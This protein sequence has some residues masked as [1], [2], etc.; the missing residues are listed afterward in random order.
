MKRLT[1]A[2]IIIAMSFTAF[3]QY[4]Q[5]FDLLNYGDFI[6]NVD[7]NWTTWSGTTGGKEDAMVDSLMSYSPKHS[8]YFSSTNPDG[9]P[10]DVVLEFG[11]AYNSGV[12]E[13]EQA[14]YIPT[15]QGAYFNFQA[16]TEVGSVW[17][18]D[19]H[20]VDD[21][22]M[23]VTNQGIDVITTTFPDEQWFEF[24]LV[25]N[26]SL[27][28]WEVF[29]DDVSQ[30][31]FQN[32]V[33]KIASIDY[34][35]NN[36]DS[37]GGNGN[38]E[39]WID[40][41]GFSHTPYVLSARNGAVLNVEFEQVEIGG[42]SNTPNVLIR[43]LGKETITS[44]DVEVEY[45]S[46][47]L[48]KQITGETIDSFETYVLK[49]TEGFTIDK[50]AT[51]LTATISNVNGGKSDN[52]PNDDIK[53]ATINPIVPAEGRV[54]I[55]E[56]ATG[57][58]CGWCPRGAVA[59]EYLARDYHGIAQGIAVH[60]GDPM[61]V[62]NYEE[63]IESLTSGYPSAMVNRVA[64]IDPSGIWSPVNENLEIAPIA[65]LKNGAKYNDATRT[66]D[67]SVSVDFNQSANS[68]WKL[69]CVLI[70]DGV[71]GYDQS[72]Y[73]SGGGNGSLIGPDGVDWADLPS[74]VPAS[75]MVY[76]HVARVIS[77]EFAGF[78][79]SFPATVNSGETHTVNFDFVLDSE[80]DKDKMHIVGILIKPNGQVEN[81]STSTIDE[82][83]TNGYADG[84]KVVSVNKLMGPDTHFEIFPN[85][86]SDQLNIV[87]SATII[88]IEIFDITGKQL[89]RKQMNQ[90][91]IVQDFSD[92]ENGIY[93][94]KAN[95][96]K[97][98]VTK[99][100]VVGN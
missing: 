16:E 82:A 58:W 76:N 53:T 68:N 85:P 3:S 14:I 79:N 64:D 47:K 31:T 17:A 1:L 15:G 42:V 22:K 94:L 87:S 8:I 5:N 19:V 46:Q 81:G 2:I 24:K 78:K 7:A 51:T 28:V 11:K 30:G 88:S 18:L 75:Q 99:R 95:T 55:V 37:Y 35:P 23:Y 92:Y 93:I 54:V 72:N 67:V 4:S 90:K 48:T 52:D 25:A 77:P 60:G 98:W 100:F 59:L 10:Q 38:S 33:N 62:T 27:N 70:E 32:S 57:T 43:N 29:I 56:E 66:L 71:T 40:D 63:G 34:Y 65:I 80:W 61:A 41:V 6:G 9:G 73:Y 44:F 20:F 26:L 91:Q 84:V 86:V 13:F 96:E 69:A 12:F 45:N 50:N 89:L 49:F 36:S 21:K 83:V 74:K 97:G 39:F